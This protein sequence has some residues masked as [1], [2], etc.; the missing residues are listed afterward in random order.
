MKSNTRLLHLPLIVLSGV[1]FILILGYAGLLGTSTWRPDEYDTLARY[2]TE[3]THFLWHRIIAWSPRPFSELLI[4]FYAALVNATKLQLTHLIMGLVWFGLFFS[5]G[6]GIIL[7]QKT[8]VPIGIRALPVILPTILTLCIAKTGEVFYWPFGSMAYMPTISAILLM[9][10]ILIWGNIQEHALPWGIS[11]S[12]LATSSEMG[13][14]FILLLFAL[15]TLSGIS[16]H[17]TTGHLNFEHAWLKPLIP[18]TLM[19]ICVL[20]LLSNGRLGNPDEAKMGSDVSHDIAAVL[21]AA[22]PE[23]TRQ[24][25]GKAETDWQGVAPYF[26]IKIFLGLFIFFLARLTPFDHQKRNVAL[27]FS[28]ACIA[29]IGLS[30]IGAYYQFGV[31]CCERHDTIRHF[32]SYIGV[33]SFSTAS[34][35]LI[36]GEKIKKSTKLFCMGSGYILVG[37]CTL[38]S[39]KKMWIDYGNY[40][41]ITSLHHEN[42]IFQQN[43]PFIFKVDLKKGYTY[44]TLPMPS[45]GIFSGS[46][47]NTPIFNKSILRFFDAKEILFRNKLEITNEFN[48]NSTE[49]L[50]KPPDWRE[51]ICITDIVRAENLNLDAKE[52]K[53]IQLTV[54]GWINL[55]DTGLNI[56]QTEIKLH[57]RIDTQDTDLILPL[58]LSDRPDV[59]QHFKRDELLTSGY[60]TTVNI[61][62]SHIRDLSII[63]TDGTLSARCP[64]RLP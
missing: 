18:S 9:L 14:F 36:P 53:A 2:R 30:E 61:P 41:N 27:S 11:A 50:K 58:E 15:L 55:P 25:L 45:E 46:E 34:A 12:I 17:K 6:M 23:T 43:P 38:V 7:T 51:M 8:R 60:T 13:A 40:H 37:L 22:I 56:S 39:A 5:I 10:A 28:I 52:V 24:I 20:A 3:G 62:F 32:L 47:P 48:L 16:R 4:Y 26:L 59:S 21:I 49:T 44:G 63:A 31:S 33:V 29:S 57:V 42:W 19:A 64:L 54:G 35:S 1:A